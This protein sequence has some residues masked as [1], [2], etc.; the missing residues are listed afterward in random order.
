MKL[1][2]WVIENLHLIECDVQE[3]YGEQEEG[4]TLYGI[5]FTKYD[6]EE[7]GVGITIK[8]LEIDTECTRC[9]NGRYIISDNSYGKCN[10]CDGRGII[11][12]AKAI[13]NSIFDIKQ[14]IELQHMLDSSSPTFI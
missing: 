10:R 3:V 8:P 6:G 7:E 11:D 9:V 13:K 5:R 4:D 14:K 2:K 12:K 1:S